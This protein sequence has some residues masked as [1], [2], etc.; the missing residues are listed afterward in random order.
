M[1]FET[2]IR[3]ELRNGKSIDDIAKIMSTAINDVLQEENQKLAQTEERKQVIE[4]VRQVFVSNYE[5]GHFDLSD[6]GALAV[7]CVEK[8]Y[9][10]WTK[11]DLQKFHQAVVDNVKILADLQGKSPMKSLAKMFND[12]FDDINNSKKTAAGAEKEK[13]VSTC[14]DKDCTCGKPRPKSDAER[15]RDFINRL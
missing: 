8:D 7:L 15:I 4:S 6:V 11:E 12:L 2:M 1:D 13:R 3:A 9:P 5:K 14:G 10:N